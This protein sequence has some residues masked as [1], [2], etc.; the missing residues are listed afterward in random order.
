[1]AKGVD[2]VNRLSQ[3]MRQE[4]GRVLSEATKSPG[5]PYD[6]VAFLKHALVNL[7]HPSGATQSR[8]TSP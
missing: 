6:E 1:L 5:L 8:T 7:S 4:P 2:T 3:V